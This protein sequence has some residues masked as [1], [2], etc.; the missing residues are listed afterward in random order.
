MSRHLADFLDCLAG[1]TK[2][3][4]FVEQWDREE[5]RTLCLVSIAYSL[6]QIA[7]DHDPTDRDSVFPRIADALERIVDLQEEQSP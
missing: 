7:Q 2:E 4:G 5:L 3:R 6:E 1:S